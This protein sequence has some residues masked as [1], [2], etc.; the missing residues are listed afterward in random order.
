MESYLC[1]FLLYL[2]VLTL[3]CGTGSVRK[4]YF[5]SQGNTVIENV[6]QIHSKTVGTP[7]CPM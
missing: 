3:L 2:N 1:S 6:R 4:R 7:H 5:N